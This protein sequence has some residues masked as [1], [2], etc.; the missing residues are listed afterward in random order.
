M[1]AEMPTPPT[2]ARMAM[3]I[4]AGSRLASS[5]QKMASVKTA[6]RIVAT[7]PWTPEAKRCVS[8]WIRCEAPSIGE[9]VVS[10]APR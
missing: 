5:G 4:R 1:N 8:S 3:T 9:T 2:A 6:S 10:Q 7:Q